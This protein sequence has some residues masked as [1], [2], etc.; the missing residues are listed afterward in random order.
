MPR[1]GRE[2]VHA[3]KTTVIARYRDGETA[4]ALAAEFGVSDAWLKK[5][6]SGWGVPVRGVREARILRARPK[7]YTVEETLVCQICDDLV[8]A[9]RA[10]RVVYDHSRATD[11]RVLLRRHIETTADHRPGAVTPPRGGSV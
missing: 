10:A 9:E 6:L 3:S 7:E 1:T 2:D 8:A 5:R 11:C 4:K